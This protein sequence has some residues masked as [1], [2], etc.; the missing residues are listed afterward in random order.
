MSTTQ[1]LKEQRPAT[2][3]VAGDIAGTSESVLRQ[4]LWI[5][6]GPGVVAVVLT[7]GLSI[8]GWLMTNQIADTERDINRVET[9]LIR[10]ETNLRED[11]AQLETRLSADIAR[12]ES[13]IS[14]V[15]SKLDS[16]ITS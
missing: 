13:Q 14:R 7:A 6:F 15:E 4:N 12:L 3:Q 11:M 2:Q 8:F 10:V 9:Q 1:T 5:R 16:L